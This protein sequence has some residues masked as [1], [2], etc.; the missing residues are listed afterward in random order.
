MDSS[1]KVNANSMTGM[2]FTSHWL[3]EF[4]SSVQE[5]PA[6]W[7]L[8]FQPLLLENSGLIQ[9]HGVFLSRVRNSIHR[10]VFHSTGCSNSCTSIPGVFAPA[11]RLLKMYGLKRWVKVSANKPSTH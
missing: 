7:R 1:L 9:K 10:S 8:K 11:I 2:K 6:R 4:V 5:R 3:C